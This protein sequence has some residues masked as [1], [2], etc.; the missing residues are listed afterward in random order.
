LRRR[1]ELIVLFA[2]TRHEK[3]EPH[4]GRRR[5]LAQDR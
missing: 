2:L 5:K 3:A 4:Q 1:W